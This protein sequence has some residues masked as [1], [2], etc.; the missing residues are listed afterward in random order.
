MSPTSFPV[1]G[2]R[3]YQ[4]E[5]VSKLLKLLADGETRLLLVAPTGS[6]KTVMAQEVMRLYRQARP[7]GKILFA[8]H[9][10]ELIRQPQRSHGSLDNVEFRTVQSV[11]ATSMP[12]TS[13]QDL[14]ILDEAHRRDG[15]AMLDTWA[16][17]AIGLTATPFRM[18]NGRTTPLS[19]YR[20]M[21]VAATPDG[22]LKDGHLA[23]LRLIG[24]PLSREAQESLKRLRREG[25]EEVMEAVMGRA[26]VIADVVKT[27]VGA[28]PRPTIVFC[29]MVKIAREVAH[30][31]KEAGVRAMVL[32]GEDSQD[33]RTKELEAFRAG[34]VDVICNADLLTEGVD[35]PCCSR[36]VMMRATTSP[37][38]YLQQVGRGTRPF[39]GKTDLEVYDH[40]G[41]IVYHGHPYA[42]RVT[43][44][45]PNIP[46]LGMPVDRGQLE[47]VHRCDKCF[48][49][50]FDR[51]SSCPMCGEKIQSS[52][53]NTTLRINAAGK[54][55][56]YNEDQV[57]L[58]QEMSDR[59]EQEKHVNNSRIR[60]LFS[61]YAR[62]GIP[63]SES[64]GAVMEA[65]MIFKA[66]QRRKERKWKDWQ[67]F[68]TLHLQS[69]KR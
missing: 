23:S 51:R 12:Q 54:L 58:A 10:V 55:V 17:P 50:F 29:P 22:L 49:I 40:V 6:G 62:L 56:E 64:R 30:R 2:L 15:L 41:N 5:A 3:P 28:G 43:S 8:A 31:F 11:A 9:R 44:M 19:E 53:R 68:V 16:G 26:D 25:F 21:V 38:V 24:P 60:Q 52:K 36:I 47:S 1:G 69:G 32:S 20:H 63:P 39:P 67:E 45:D 57:K 48:A 13:S 65:F 66:D 34:E 4:Q 59:R 37:I 35:V 18:H 14:L 42:D 33:N 46:Y 61:H 7:S 27:W